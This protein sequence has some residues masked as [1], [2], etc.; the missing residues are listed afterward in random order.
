M[1]GN[2]EDNVKRDALKIREK[3][4]EGKKRAKGGT[5]RGDN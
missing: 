2:G 1:E 4:Q 5:R 3:K